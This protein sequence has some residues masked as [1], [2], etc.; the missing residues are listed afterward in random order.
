MSLR[1]FSTKSVFNCCKHTSLDI[2]VLNVCVAKKDK[3][4]NISVGSRPQIAVRAV[5][6]EKEFAS[7]GDISA[8][9]KVAVDEISFGKDVRG[10]GKYR[11]A[12]AESLIEKAIVEVSK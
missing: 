3:E 8:T 4:I 11:K 12:L 1:T 10:S 2:A 6:A 7:N 9:V 5:S